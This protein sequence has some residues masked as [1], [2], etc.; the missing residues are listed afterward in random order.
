MISIKDKKHCCGCSACASIC[1]KHSIVMTEDNEG[2]LYPHVDMDTCIDCGLCEKACNELHPFEKGEPQHVYAAI[3]KN[4]AI[5]MR[6]SSGGVFYA[7]AE[8]VLNEGGVV[9]GARFD[10]NWQV[11]IDYAEDMQGVEAFMGSKYVQARVGEAYKDAKRFLQQ[12]RKVL[13]SGT[14]CQVAGLH[15]FLRK[16]YDN[17]LSID[18]VC[19]GT[20]SPKVWKLYLQEVI[21]KLHR[22]SDIEFRNKANGWKN[23]GLNLR[24]NDEDQTVSLLSS[25]HQNPYMK[26]FLQDIILRPSCYDCKAKGCRSQSNITIADF[27][28]VNTVFPVMDDDKGTSLVFINTDHGATL[29]DHQQFVIA[30]TTYERVKPLNPA[31]YRSCSVHPKRDEFFH[32]LDEENLIDLIE[33]CTRPPLK[34][35]IRMGLGR[36]KT[37]VL[38]VLTSRFWGGRQE[39]VRKNL[40]S[41]VNCSFLAIRK[42]LAFA[43]G[44]KAKDG[45][46][47]IWKLESKVDYNKIIPLNSQRTLIASA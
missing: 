28:G 18:F 37:F 3:N 45:K 10:D 2:F 35:R 42:S 23:F 24:Y 38:R 33:Y 11:V 27:W 25:F 8:K 6:S 41:I 20:P 22:I 29:L 4:E 32:R 17:L 9:F 34:Q 1:P 14:P 15:Q 12:G 19:H 21:G 26:V 31:C 13:F 47:M 40:V 30:E 7:L 16:P 44:V 43:S 5:R 39:L 46:A 36:C